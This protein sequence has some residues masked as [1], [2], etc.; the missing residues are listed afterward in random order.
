[1]PSRKKMEYMR[2]KVY[3]HFLITPNIMVRA[4]TI[5]SRRDTL[6]VNHWQ[7]SAII[8][9]IKNIVTGTSGWLLR[10]V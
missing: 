4:K 10:K 9:K 1:M 3:L 8:P 2:V 6:S 5:K 7:E